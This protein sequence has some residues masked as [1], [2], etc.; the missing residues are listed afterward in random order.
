MELE[1]LAEAQ[2][3]SKVD[4]TFSP[5]A[6]LT[7][8]LAIAGAWGSGSPAAVPAHGED[9]SAQACRR[10]IVESTR[11]LLTARPDHDGPSG[12]VVHATGIDER[13]SA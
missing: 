5:S 9:L 6:L 13:T 4:A 2:S 8:V 3:D 7:L 1:A 12:E 10:A 11:R